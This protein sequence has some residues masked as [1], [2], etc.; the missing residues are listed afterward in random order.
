M[1]PAR[2]QVLT[3]RND[4]AELSR[5][6]ACIDEFFA[7]LQPDDQ[8]VLAFQLSLEEVVTNV[9]NHGYRNGGEHRFAVTFSA[10]GDRV[11]AIVADDAPAFN[12]LARP[13]VDINAPLEERPIGG[14]GI[15]LV[16]K[17]MD[18]VRY[19]HRDGRNILTLVRALRRAAP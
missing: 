14:L 16:K 10:D 11:T 13:E 17:L 1:T 18:E 8:D 4:L 7:P 6:A 12:P 19:E 15:H 3:L 2:Q 5:L 9:I